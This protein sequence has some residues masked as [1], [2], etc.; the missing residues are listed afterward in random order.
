MDET[1][2]KRVLSRFKSESGEVLEGL[3]DLPI[4][5]SVTNLQRMCNALLNQVRL[6]YCK[7]VYFTGFIKILEILPLLI[8]MYMIFFP[9]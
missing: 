3:L 5:V 6:Y 2:C 1:N 8:F 9:G 4:D 7:R